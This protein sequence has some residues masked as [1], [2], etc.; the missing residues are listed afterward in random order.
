VELCPVDFR[1]ERLEHLGDAARPLVDVGNDCDG[2]HVADRS[3]VSS[4]AIGLWPLRSTFGTIGTVAKKKAT[5]YVDD[6]V[7]R[8]TRAAAA[9]TGRSQSDIVEAALRRY[10]GFELLDRIRARSDLT[11]EEALALAVEATHASR[12]L[13]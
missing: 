10:L 5:I 6:A 2:F 11:E 9:R 12:A 7:L 3:Q 13:T 8:A 1:F 4:A